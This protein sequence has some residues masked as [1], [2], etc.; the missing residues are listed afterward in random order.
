[1]TEIEEGL[2]AIGRLLAE[3]ILEV[4][5]AKSPVVQSNNREDFCSASKIEPAGRSEAHMDAVQLAEH[6]AISQQ[7]V[8]RLAR[9]GTIPSI[10]LGRRTMRFNVREVMAAI[11]SPE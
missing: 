3:G 11:K 1:M 8:W 10:R 6:L 5:E 4:L 2:K 9:E 7:S